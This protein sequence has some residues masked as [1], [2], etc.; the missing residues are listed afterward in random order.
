ML[1]GCGSARSQSKP[2]PD[3]K[4]A[5]AN[6]YLKAWNKLA[7]SQETNITNLNT[8]IS[9]NDPLSAAATIQLE[10][11]SLNGFDATVRAITFPTEDAADVKA[12]STATATLESDLGALS[13][14]TGTTDQYNLLFPTVQSDQTAVQVAAKTLAGDLGLSL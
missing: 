4:V 11:L 10:I 2:T 14:N 6:T 7:D 12:L 1:L 8:Y 13:M 5:A 9:S 3:V